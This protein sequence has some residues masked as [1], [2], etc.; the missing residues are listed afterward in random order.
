M[1]QTEKSGP[2]GSAV[3]DVT[4]VAALASCSVP[5]PTSEL[6]SSLEYSCHYGSYLQY[7]DIFPI[8]VSQSDPI[9]FSSSKMSSNLLV[10]C[11]FPF[12]DFQYCYAFIYFYSLFLSIFSGTSTGLRETGE[13]ISMLSCPSW[14]MFRYFEILDWDAKSFHGL[15]EKLKMCPHSWSHVPCQL[16]GQVRKTT[17]KWSASRSALLTWPLPDFQVG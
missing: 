11:L 2:A 7:T 16:W 17:C 8:I 15:M 3:W 6:H 5:G 14:T 13:I 9:H 4:L 12:L 1:S 10:C